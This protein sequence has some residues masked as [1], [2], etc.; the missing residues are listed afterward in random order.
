MEGE[1]SLEAELDNILIL[2]F[3]HSEPWENKFL[4]FKCPSLGCFVMAAQ[5]DTDPQTEAAEWERTR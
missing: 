3:Q 5:A 4:L 2:D 1:S